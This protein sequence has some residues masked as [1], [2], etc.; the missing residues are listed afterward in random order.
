[1]LAIADLNDRMGKWQGWDDASPARRLAQTRL[2]RISAPVLLTL[3]LLAGLFT[4]GRESPTTVA[5]LVLEA[6]A[7]GLWAVRQDALWAAYLGSLAWSAAGLIGGLVLAGRSGPGTRTSAADQC[8]AG[9]VVQPSTRSA[10][11]AAG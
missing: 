4:F 9:R 7:L 8:R 5:T 11:S 2:A 3:T 1:M 10:C 6:M